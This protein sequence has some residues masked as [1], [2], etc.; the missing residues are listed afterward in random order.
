MKQLWEVLKGLA[1]LGFITVAGL[2]T[3]MVVM[4]IVP[5]LDCLVHGTPFFH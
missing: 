2:F 1:F 4:L 5:A 3:V